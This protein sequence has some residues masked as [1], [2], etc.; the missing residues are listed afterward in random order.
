M[1]R[2]NIALAVLVVALVGVVVWRVW[3]PSE[4]VYKG[5]TLTTWLS[6]DPGE[7]WEIL[8]TGPYVSFPQKNYPISREARVAVEEAGTNAI[9]TLL[10][11]LRRR[12]SPLKS[13]LM[14][15]LQRQNV[16]RIDYVPAAVWN[17]RAASAFRSLEFRAEDAVPALIRIM[18][19]D[20]PLESRCAAIEALNWIGP[21]AQGAVPALLRWATNGPAPMLQWPTNGGLPVW[22][23]P[24]N[25]DQRM[26]WNARGALRRIDP[27]TAA[28]AGITQ[29]P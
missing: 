26:Q 29:W 3:P 18:N 23:W 15:L 11:L 16:V 14:S 27:L 13:K 2:V 21:S 6:A 9:P 10:R 17:H 22:R 7:V 8:M 25:A 1:K 28:E 20:D 24:A 5:R 4:P 19:G 12:D